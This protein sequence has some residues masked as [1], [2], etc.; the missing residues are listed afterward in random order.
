MIQEAPIFVAFILPN[1]S[2]NENN[3]QIANTV[4]LIYMYQT[5]AIGKPT[6]LIIYASLSRK[7]KSELQNFICC[8]RQRN[9]K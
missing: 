1:V 3:L 9:E 6:D 5:F 7:V 4:I 2:W 8:K